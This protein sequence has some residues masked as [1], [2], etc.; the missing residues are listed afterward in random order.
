MMMVEM[1]INSARNRPN[2]RRDLVHHAGQQQVFLLLRGI[3]SHV[4][5]RP[6]R[7]GYATWVRPVP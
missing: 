6:K 2:C 1:T 3:D 4:R 7:C 5:P